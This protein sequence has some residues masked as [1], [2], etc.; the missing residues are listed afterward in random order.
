MVT[1]MLIH[2]GTLVLLCV[3][4]LHTVSHMII[5]TFHDNSWEV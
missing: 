5:Y 2:M 4:H 1:R 3:C